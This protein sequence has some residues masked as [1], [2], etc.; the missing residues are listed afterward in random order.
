MKKLLIFLSFIS[1]AA[2]CQKQTNTQTATNPCDPDIMCT[3]DFRVINLKVMDEDSQ[4]VVLDSF[5]TSLNGSEI[6]IEAN[7][8]ENNEGVYPVATDGQMNQLSFEGDKATFIGIKNGKK[9]VKHQLKI[10]KDCCH[11]VLMEGD[12]KVV[13][14]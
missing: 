10:G 14:S 6:K 1:M 13:I 9:V 5:Y 3:M 11:V 7:L 4:A 12:E 2:T 8:F